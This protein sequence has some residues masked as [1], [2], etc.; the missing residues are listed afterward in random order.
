MG[1]KKVRYGSRILAADPRERYLDV[2]VFFGGT[3]AVGGTALLKLLSIYEEMMTVHPP[4]PDE[5]PI[6]VATGRTRHER[7]VFTD[8][9]FHFLRSR[10]S[11]EPKAVRSGYLTESGVFIALEPFDLRALPGLDVHTKT[12][13]PSHHAQSLDELGT[14]EER[15]AAVESYLLDLGTSVGAP[16]DEIVGSIAAKLSAMRPMTSFLTAYRDAWLSDRRQFRYRCVLNAIPLPSFLSYP[17]EI[18]VACSYIPAITPAHV[19]TLKELLVTTIREDLSSV[20][21]ALAESVIVAHTTSVGGM[22]DEMIANDGSAHRQ[23]RLG[24]AHSAADEKL[25]VKQ[26][27]AEELTDQYGA[28]GVK[29]LITAAAIG[30]DEVRVRKTV[31]LHASAKRQLQAE[32]DQGEELYPESVKV[33]V[34]VVL[35]PKTIPLDAPP[36]QRVR[37]ERRR[38]V[39]DLRPTYTLRSGENGFFSVANAEALYRVMRVASTG[40]LGLMLATVALFGDDPQQPWFDV[41][42]G[43]CYYTETDNSRQVFDFLSQPLLRQPQLSGLE[44]L[45]LQDLGSAKHQGELHTL[46]LLILLHRLRTLDV[47]SI[48]PYV[49]LAGFDARDFFERNSRPLTLEDVDTWNV[50]SIAADLCV[51]VGADSAEQLAPLA[52]FRPHAH[53]ALFPEKVAAR[54]KVLELV[55]R[56]VWAI[57]SLGTPIIFEVNHK[58]MLRCGPFIAPLEVLLCQ[59]DSIDGYLRNAHKRSANPCSFEEYRDFQLCNAGFID[60]RPHAFVCTAKNDRLDLRGR[61]L[62]ATTDEEL[63]AALLTLEPY[64]YFTTSGLLA[65]LFRLKAFYSLFNEA[66]LQLGTLQETQWQMPRDTNGHLLLIPGVAEAMRMVAEGLEKTTGTER[67]DGFWGYERRSVPDRRGQV[68]PRLERASDRVSNL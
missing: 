57:P 62:H 58:A 37:F 59:S 66:D 12:A 61:V 24:F 42:T 27:F 65:V 5:V 28:I 19:S 8:R 52:P 49:D 15:H 45:A 16:P 20:Q 36:P 25:I 6:L 18:D 53:D 40:E 2:H 13:D 48:P 54:Q 3:G 23:I 38:E 31:P 29:I 46:G 43:I 64:S 11:A 1:F 32:K 30:V 10:G 7:R 17:R 9:L 67:L 41:N 39:D 51:L 50:R 35:H 33:P 21:S 34:V 68:L 44:P 56:A 4:R 63:R 55:K 14:D 47:D 22:Y 60:V 26:H